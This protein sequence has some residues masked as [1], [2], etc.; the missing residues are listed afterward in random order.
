MSTGYV[1]TIAWRINLAFFESFCSSPDLANDRIAD[2]YQFYRLVVTRNFHLRHNHVEVELASIL[3]LIWKILES[4]KCKLASLVSFLFCWSFSW[5]MD[6]KILPPSS[7]SWPSTLCWSS[8]PGSGEM[9]LETGL[10]LSSIYHQQYTFY[11][12]IFHYFSIFRNLNH[13]WPIIIDILIPDWGP[14]AVPNSWVGFNVGAPKTPMLLSSN[15]FAHIYVHM[16][17]LSFGSPR[18]PQNHWSQNVL[19]NLLGSFLEV[20]RLRFHDE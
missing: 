2:C 16:H 10:C 4:I 18:R 6:W 14:S 1:L 3:A 13:I 20:L 7:L 8:L 17:E 11:K 9:A 12:C 15:K 19:R 5:P